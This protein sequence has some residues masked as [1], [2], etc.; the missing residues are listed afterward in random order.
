MTWGLGGLLTKCLFETFEKFFLEFVKL[1]LIVAHSTP[2]SA[3]VV[4]RD[5]LLKGKDRYGS[6]PCINQFRSAAFNT[7]KILMRRSMVLSLPLP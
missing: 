3:G 7:E 5:S 6:P 4:V 2:L 1:F